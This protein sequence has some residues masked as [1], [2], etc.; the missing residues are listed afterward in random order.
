MSSIRGYH[1]PDLVTKPAPS[2]AAASAP[3]S[4]DAYGRRFATGTFWISV[5]RLG[6]LPLGLLIAIALTRALGP[7]NFGVFAVSLSIYVWIQSALNAAFNRTTVTLIASGGGAS[8][9]AS[10]LVQWETGFGVLAGVLLWVTAPW[11]A[12]VLHAAELQAPLQ[13]LAFGLPL[14]AITQAHENVLLGRRDFARTAWLPLMNDVFRLVLTVLFLGLGLGVTG[15]VLGNLGGLAAEFALVRRFMPVPLFVRAPLPRRRFARLAAPSW[16][17]SFSKQLANRVALWIVQALNGAAGAGLYGAA[18][19][20]TLPASLLASAIISPLL[21]TLTHAWQ[22]GQTA[23]AQAVIRHTLRL[24]FCLMPFA[25]LGAGAAGPLVRVV[26][27]ESFAGAAGPVEW[28]APGSVALLMLSLIST[29]L[30]ALGRPGATAWLTAPLLPLVLVG[31]WALVPRFGAAGAAAAVAL[32]TTVDMLAGLWVLARWYHAGLAG[33]SLARVG[34]VSALAFVAAHAWTVPGI[35]VIPQL[36]VL[37][38][39]VVA[40]LW[41]TRELTAS[42]M[43]FARSLFTRERAGRPTASDMTA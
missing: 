10:A 15:A 5:G 8:P 1:W 22:N 35:W 3:A 17:D 14:F 9:L 13:L 21:A 34:S 36:V 43:A 16:F 2:P 39:G 19:N 4:A 30:I 29:I 24:A 28:L 26:F 31:S 6:V 40:L 38:T 12:T 42:D 32:V 41:L 7:E 25:L 37:S 18:Q 33:L 20:L 27:G 11:I 23:A